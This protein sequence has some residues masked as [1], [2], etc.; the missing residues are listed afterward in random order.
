MAIE[1]IDQEKCIGC[2]QCFNTCYGGVI[3]MDKDSKKA[4]AKYPQDCSVCCW[5][6][7]LCPASAVVFTPT[8]TS[9]VFTSWG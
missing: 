3:L 7:A 4:V 6:V 8:K 1:K 2:E 9:P 5:C